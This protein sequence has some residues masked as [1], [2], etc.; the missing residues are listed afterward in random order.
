MKNQTRKFPPGLLKTLRRDFLLLGLLALLAEAALRHYA[1]QFADQFTDFQFTRGHPFDFN[2]KGYRGPLPPKEKRKG[3]F[4]VLCLG[5]STTFG[6][7]VATTAT[8]P[9]RLEE[10]LRARTKRPVSVINGALEGASL[11]GLLYTFDHDWK[12]YRPDWVVLGLYANMVAGGWILRKDGYKPPWNGRFEYALEHPE[13]PLTTKLNRLLHKVCLPS[14]LLWGMHVFCFQIGLQGHR[15]DPADSHGF[16]LAYGWKQGDLPP[17]LPG[18]A[19][20]VLERDL[21]LLKKK[22][23][24][25]GARLLVTFLPCRFSLSDRWTDN[26]QAVPRERFTIDP[27]E[28]TRD[29]CAALGIPYVDSR[30]SLRK[31]RRELERKGRSAP[32]YIVGDFGHLDPE[33]HRAV[34]RGIRAF[35]V[36]A[37]GKSVFPAPDPKEK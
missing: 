31:G 23:A 30:A 2:P 35:L 7:G 11:P 27:V 25:R 34:A 29:L 32:M 28:K 9:A 17:D 18:K 26:D 22:T 16:Y 15:V 4:R 8:W 1:P 6:T 14:A 24:S 10:E 12:G 21:A 5:D 13:A 19:W 37:A 3:E 33:G 36:K 20:K